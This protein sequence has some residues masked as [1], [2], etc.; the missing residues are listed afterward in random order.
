MDK[1][2]S[3][4]RSIALAAVLWSTGGVLIKILPLDPIIIAALRSWF[5]GIAL[6]PFIRPKELKINFELIALII[7][8][9]W[10]SVSFVA[11]TKWTAAANAIALQ[12]TAP[13][14]VFMAILIKSKKFSWKEALPVGIIAAGIIVFLL[15]PAVGTSTLGNLVGLNCGIAFAITTTLLQ[16]AGG[17]NGTGIISIC[18]LMA[19]PLIWMLAPTK[20]FSLFEIDIKAW[21]LLFCLGVFQL[22][23]GYIFYNRG[24]KTT[25]AQKATMLA[26][27]EPVLNPVWVFIFA[28]E[29]PT[30][31]GL[32][33]EALI[34][35]GLLADAII[36]PN[37]QENKS[38]SGN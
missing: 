12:S 3:G 33:G 9:A 36:N 35:S 21:V 24:L 25:T 18:N 38:V 14:W 6:L 2:I 8:Y 20:L 29:I 17:V 13:L 22:G 32:L 15:E 23:L 34:I 10:L 5:A 30:I 1:V 16:R 11:A 19:A 28:S 27:L 4:P 31:Y 37:S 7:S 26:L